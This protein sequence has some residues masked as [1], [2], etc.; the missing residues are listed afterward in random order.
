MRAVKKKKKTKQN[1][2][3]NKKQDLSPENNPFTYLN[4]KSQ[5]NSMLSLP[6]YSPVGLYDLYV[7]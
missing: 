2:N 6:K 1:N 4:S 3:N 7:G 5:V